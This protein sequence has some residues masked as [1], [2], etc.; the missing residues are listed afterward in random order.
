MYK[1]QMVFAQVMDLVPWRRFQT[2]IDRYRGDVKT[3]ALST[4]EF[5]KIMAFAQITSRESLNETILCLNAVPVHLYH[6]GLPVA[7]HAHSIFGCDQGVTIARSDPLLCG[8][9]R[10]KTR[11]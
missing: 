1:G 7:V 2:C 3:H 6:L 10:K 4:R 8:S 11:R 5:F 9:Q